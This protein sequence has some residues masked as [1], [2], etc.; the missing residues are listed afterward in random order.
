VHM[1]SGGTDRLLRDYLEARFGAALDYFIIESQMSPDAKGDMGVTG[2][3]R[4]GA[5]DKKVFFTVTVNL[6]S[7]EVQN[8]QEYS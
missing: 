4:K 7:R 2:T 3:Y 5:S 6:A 8:L 1:N